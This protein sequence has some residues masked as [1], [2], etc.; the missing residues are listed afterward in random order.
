MKIY[1]KD[2]KCPKCGGVEFKDKFFFGYD[3]ENVERRC[4]GC[5]YGCFRRPLDSVPTNGK[6][7]LLR[8]TFMRKWYNMAELGREVERM[9]FWRGRW[10]Y[11][12]KEAQELLE[13]L[14]NVPD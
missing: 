4:L 13:K 11:F 6:L 1:N 5:G 7:N 2:E 3:R 9:S 14:N 10:D 12:N 8:K